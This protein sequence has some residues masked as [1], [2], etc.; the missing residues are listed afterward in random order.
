MLNVGGQLM[1]D[2]GLRLAMLHRQDEGV[3]HTGGNPQSGDIF[4][5]DEGENVLY[6]RNF[7]KH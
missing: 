4:K 7:L 2:N 5:T 1:K 3:V 6:G